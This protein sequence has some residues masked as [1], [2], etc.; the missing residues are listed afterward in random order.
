MFNVKRMSAAITTHT[1]ETRPLPLRRRADLECREQH[2]GGTRY[3]HVKDPVSLRYFQLRPEEHAVLMMLDGD[4]SLREIRRRFEQRFAPQRLS[5][6]QLQ[7]FLAM[8]HS[9]GLIVSDS[10]GQAEFLRQRQRS[11]QRQQLLG[12]CMNLLAI[13]FR[14]YDPHRLLNWLQPQTRF[15]FSPWCVTLCV[16]LMIGAL[17]LAG[18]QFDVLVSRLPRFHEFFSVGNLIW[19]TLIFAVTKV[20][21]E[22]G[23]A[24]S[25]RHFGGE[26]H[27]MGVM[28]LALT[29]V[30]Y[31]N[32]SDAWMLPNRWHR[33]VI[34]AAGMYVEWLL[35]S[36]CLFL[37]W[38]SLPGLFNGLCLNVVFVCSFTTLLFNGN[39]LLRYDGYYIF[40]DLVEIPNL[41]QQAGA[42][43]RN[44]LS[45]FFFDSETGNRRLLPERRRTLLVTWFV[46]ALVYR[47]IVIWGILWFVHAVLEPYGLQPLVVYM[48]VTTIGTMLISPLLQIR[49]R[50]SSPFWSRTVNWPHFRF[51]LL[52]VS[53]ALAALLFIPLPFSVKA[54]AVIQSEGSRSVYVSHVGTLTE[55]IEAGQ[56]VA[57]DA[58]VG[59]LANPKLEWEVSRLDGQ[60][61]L[62][63]QELANLEDR[64]LNDASVEA[65]IPTTQQRLV[66]K[67]NELHQRTSD[68]DRLTLRSP[69][70]GVVL[71]P[72]SRDDS[73][74]AS[75]DERLP[76]WKGTPLD[77][78]NLGATLGTG[79]EFC[80]IG[81]PDRF[82]AIV[83]VDQNN[84]EFVS[85][86]QRVELLIDHLGERLLEG[87]IVEVAEIDI[88]VAP[89][90][91][92]AH[93]D[94]PTTLDSDG[95]PRPVSTAYQARIRL[96]ETDAP[97]I[98]R[99]TGRTRIESAPRSLADRT[100]TFLRRTFR[101]K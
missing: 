14:G 101:F 32:V 21:H 39:P 4:V 64:R 31:C 10:A 20:L 6:T 79:T 70:A 77:R 43:V 83:A 96:D 57:L 66:E 95:I 48:A 80:Q 65:L 45:L 28:L 15:L 19:L 97:L 93:D 60:V 41:R 59:R 68:L 90:E 73:E 62:L 38:F 82:E 2:I 91:L 74:A 63:K 5:L 49:A 11:S 88:D 42:L 16:S 61:E 92:I 7:S 23:H 30:L 36:A 13:R 84:V 22:L 27:E 75:D 85:E 76:K 24:V 3:W 25:C 78:Q 56:S 29:P 1:A 12:R 9:S 47:F 50:L 99:G 86:G 40:S 54:P 69:I 87:T 81:Q 58:V 72:P 46:A 52:L 34:S 98:L 37:W 100:L 33:V 26:C 8:L 55:A 17:L 18:L 35:A 94:F 51:R 71:P 53:G 44:L 67:Q 89:P